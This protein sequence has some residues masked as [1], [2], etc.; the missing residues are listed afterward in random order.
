MMLQTHS[1]DV[2]HLLSRLEMSS[3]RVEAAE[4]AAR[5][6]SSSERAR[7]CG[8][9]SCAALGGVASDGS[10]TRGGVF[11]DNLD[12]DSA[13]PVVSNHLLGFTAV[14]GWSRAPP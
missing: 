9:N 2:T 14:S 12:G 5:V 4:Q 1:D 6:P 13:P 10:L 7:L 8:C 11:E 3:E